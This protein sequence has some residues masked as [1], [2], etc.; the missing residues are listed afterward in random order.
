MTL[1][2]YSALV[3]ST[4]STFCKKVEGGAIVVFYFEG[5]WA[6][7]LSYLQVLLAT[8][9]SLATEEGLWAPLTLYNVL[10]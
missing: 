3:P 9:F 6:N 7:L 1:I 2:L 4:M 10:L 8:F 5:Q